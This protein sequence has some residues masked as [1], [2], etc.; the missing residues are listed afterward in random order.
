VEGW[1]GGGVA[2]W[3]GGGPKKRDG[4]GVRPRWWV[5]AERQKVL[6]GTK[7]QEGE[8]VAKVW[9]GSKGGRA[10]VGEA[11]AARA[12]TR[13][14][15]GTG[16]EGGRHATSSRRNDAA[17]QKRTRKAVGRGGRGCRVGQKPQHV[18][19][20]GWRRRRIARAGLK[21]GGMCGGFHRFAITNSC[22]CGG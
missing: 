7:W 17:S 5:A 13:L 3:R 20:R 10:P 1:R 19:P 15:R 22:A 6:E 9:V 16:G 14:N 11:P 2:G 21:V 12:Q 18:N 4:Q 8:R